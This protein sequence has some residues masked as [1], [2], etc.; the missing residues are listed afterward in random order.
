MP[1]SKRPDSAYWQIRFQVAGIEVRRS[2]DTTDKSA[3]KELEADLRRDL[4][5][6]LRNGGGTLYTW[7]DAVK[8][9]E[10]E[11]AKQKSWERKRRA[12]NTLNEYLSG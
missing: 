8:Q 4:E 10:P 12:I 5:E 11:D 3:A 1:L 2:S 9:C 6:K 7:D